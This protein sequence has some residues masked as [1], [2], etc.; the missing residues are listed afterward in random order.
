MSAT[1]S[2]FEKLFSI[3][4]PHHFQYHGRIIFNIMAAS[5]S[6][7]LAPSFSISWPHH[8]QYHGPNIFNIMTASFSISWPHHFQ[9]HGI[10]NIMAPSFSISWPH[11]F[12]T[13]GPTFSIP[14]L[15]QDYNIT[16]FRTAGQSFNERCRWF[17]MSDQSDPANR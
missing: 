11:M 1:C 9:Y 17:H 14:A 7:S 5:F 13:S 15:F 10:F 3:S 2:I 4:W 16:F 6:I 8:F 12:N